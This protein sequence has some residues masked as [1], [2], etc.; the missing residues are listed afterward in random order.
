MDILQLKIHRDNDT[1]T[2]LRETKASLELD[3]LNIEIQKDK[4]E[5]RVLEV[6]RQLREIDK[7]VSKRVN[8]NI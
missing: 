8:K 6:N 4:T 2:K 7:E 3:L 1:Y 5:R